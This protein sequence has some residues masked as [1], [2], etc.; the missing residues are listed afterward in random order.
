MGLLDQQCPLVSAHEIALRLETEKKPKAG[1]VSDLRR[2]S[3][4][5]VEEMPPHESRH[6]CEYLCL[7]YTLII[8]MHTWFIL[9]FF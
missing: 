2:D 4:Q 3:D 9:C 7:I 8:V 5:I 1:K 6:Q